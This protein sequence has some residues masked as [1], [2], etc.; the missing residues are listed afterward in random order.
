LIQAE[1][2]ETLQG[3]GPFTVFAPTDQAF[4]DAGIDLAALDSLEGKAQLS[5]ILLYHVYAGTVLST[6]ITEGMTLQMVNGKNATFTLSSSIDGANITSVDIVTSNGIIHVIDAVLIPQAEVDSTTTGDAVESEEE[7][8][9]IVLIASIIG[10]VL[11]ILIIG[12]LLYS[13]GREES[14]L[15]EQKDFSSNGLAAT[16]QPAS[17]YSYEPQQSTYTSQYAPQQSQPLQPVQV[18]PVQTQVAQPVAQVQATQPIVE[19]QQT[20]AITQTQAS[21]TAIQLPE[22]LQQWTDDSGYTWRRMSDGSTMWWNG[23]DWQPYS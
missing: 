22:V 23:T 12:G 15:T 14:S 10:I 18:Q 17:T 16:P 5:D 21:Q 8:S 19:A 3:E 1:L 13:R 4:A 9:N 2:V 7:D 6:D 11:V 20:Q